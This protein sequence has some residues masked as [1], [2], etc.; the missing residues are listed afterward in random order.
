MNLKQI[1]AEHE[2]VHFYSDQKLGLEA[3]VAV[4]TTFSGMS[5]GG[6]RIREFS[7]KEEAISD[8]LR[9]SKHM[10]YKSLLAGLNM[11][12]GKSVIITKPGFK[13]TPELLDSF[14]RF[15]NSLGGK[16]VVSVDMGSDIEDMQRIHKTTPHVIGYSEQDH[17]AGD[18]GIYTAK[19]V[20]IGMKAAAKE[21]WGQASLKDKKISVI[22][23]G[24]VGI[25]LCLELI[26]EGAQLI[27]SD[28]D[29]DQIQIIKDQAP[30]TLVVDPSQAHAVE[31]DIFSPC[32]AGASLNSETVLELKCKVIA[33]SANNQCVDNSIGKEIHQRKI[34]YLPDF[35][36]NS[37][38]L[39]GVVIRGIR[40]QSLEETNKKIDQIATII[41]VILKRSIQTDTPTSEIALNIA[42][43]KYKIMYNK[44]KVHLQHK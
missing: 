27:I 34:Y 44:T 13:K 22:G 14:A 17:G 38:G 8:V 3:I 40:K 4:H 6:C 16:Y 26:K 9:L 39:I 2:S 32:A 25:P 12:G 24:G 35:A 33:G 10:T 20:L 15:I 11:G 30:D 29:K 1:S 41:Q 31:C 23:L 28:I 36:I 19:G 18:P 37:G 42:I 5:L 43:E 21:L 7:S